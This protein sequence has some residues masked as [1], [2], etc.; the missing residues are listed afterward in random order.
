MTWLI[1]Q[2]LCAQFA[3]E[4]LP[5][6]QLYGSDSLEAAEREIQHFFPPQHTVALIKPHVTQEQRG[7]YIKIEPMYTFFFNFCGILQSKVER[8]KQWAP[9][10]SGGSA[11][12]L[13]CERFWPDFLYLIT[14][15]VPCQFSEK[16]SGWLS[17]PIYI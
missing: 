10:L 3:I 15:M 12:S 17:P 6:N 1:F 8:I 4:G 11:P 16:S 7:K 9:S 2:S 14:L 5:I 13:G